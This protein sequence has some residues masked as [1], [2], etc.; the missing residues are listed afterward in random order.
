MMCLQEKLAGRFPTFE[1]FQTRLPD[2]TLYSYGPESW[3]FNAGVIGIHREDAKYLKNAL[4][5]CDDLLLQG[6]RNHVCEQF[7]VSEALRIA[8]LKILEAREWI[9]HYYRSSAKQYMHDHFPDYA[10]HLKKE[11]WDFDRPLPYSYPRVQWHKWKR[12]IAGNLE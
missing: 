11:L 3:M 1:G 10:A 4:N 8:G 5:I 6:R 12:R 7:A 2:G 9:H